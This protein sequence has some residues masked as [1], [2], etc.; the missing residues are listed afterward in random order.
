MCTATAGMLV[1]SGLQ[2]EAAADRWNIVFKLYLIA[3][4]AHGFQSPYQIP[5]ILE[6]SGLIVNIRYTF[7]RKWCIVAAERENRMRIA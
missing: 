2:L 1:G 7:N 5:A 6:E 3:Q 4:Y